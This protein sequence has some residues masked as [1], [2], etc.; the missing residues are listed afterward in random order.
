MDADVDL[1]QARSFQTGRT[2]TSARTTLQ[3]VEGRKQG[4][5]RTQHLAAPQSHGRLLAPPPPF[6]QRVGVPLLGVPRGA[7]G[8]APGHCHLHTQHPAA[9]KA[10]R[11]ASG[12]KRSGRRARGGRTCLLSVPR[13]SHRWNPRERE[14]AGRSQDTLGARRREPR[15][16]AGADKVKLGVRRTGGE[17]TA[18][19]FAPCKGITEG[20]KI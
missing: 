14:S 10:P 12:V 15:A 2:R 3:A 16:D 8:L 13:G 17:H 9:P 19:R 11:E 1:Y 5:G 18:K 4:P 7:G 6:D 20:D